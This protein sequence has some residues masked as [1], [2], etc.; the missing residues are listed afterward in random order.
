MWLD[1]RVADSSLPQLLGGGMYPMGSSRRWRSSTMTAGIAQL[2][3]R[4]PLL[5]SAR[6][7]ADTS[8]ASPWS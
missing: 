5:Y 2:S 8:P 6:S 1:W 7:A 4:H 3:L